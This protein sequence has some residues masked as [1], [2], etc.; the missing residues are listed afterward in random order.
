M[1]YINLELTDDEI[2]VLSEVAKDLGCNSTTEKN[3]EHAI[4]HVMR[5]GVKDHYINQY[6]L[7]SGKWCQ[8]IA[9]NFVRKEGQ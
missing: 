4:L 5:F 1:P 2:K 7:E 8:A 9:N 6:G 3:L